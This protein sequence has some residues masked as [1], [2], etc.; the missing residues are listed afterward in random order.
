METLL[1]AGAAGVS[2]VGLLVAIAFWTWLWGPLG[3]LMATPLTVCLVVVGKYVASMSFLA[4][5]LGDQPVLEPGAAFYQR[6]VAGDRDEAAEILESFLSRS[7]APETAFDELVV[8]ALCYARRDVEAGHLSP[9]E[10][11]EITIGAARIVDD[12]L[13]GS[14]LALRDGAGVPTT[15]AP[16]AVLGCPAASEA[17]ALALRCLQRLLDPDAIAL[18]I[19]SPAL[20]SSEAVELVG[21]RAGSTVC[22]VALPPGELNHARYLCKRLRAAYPRLRI[23]VG[24]WGPGAL[25]GQ[26]A[27]ALLAAGADA[28]ATTLLESRAQLLGDRLRSSVTDVA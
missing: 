13:D 14:E 7:D 19:V 8:P 23:L 24:R 2:K 27:E 26:G 9:D 5:L 10:E 20:L 1:Y 17:D 4:T 28:V 25:G 3:L 6:L 16:V 12:V 15:G 22:V 11:R 18:E 21:E